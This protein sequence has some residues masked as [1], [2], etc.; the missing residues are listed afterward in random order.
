MEHLSNIVDSVLYDIELS[1]FSETGEEIEPN[2][3]TG[4]RSGFPEIDKL[5]CGFQRG[6]M[7]VISG[8]PYM[9]KSA[10][11]LSMINHRQSK[12]IYFSTRL[13]SNQLTKMLIC[14]YAEINLLV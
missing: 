9:G 13:S 12:I 1:R 14:N 5:T 8:L 11:L 3:V 2:G 7:I 6:E 10:F 4:F